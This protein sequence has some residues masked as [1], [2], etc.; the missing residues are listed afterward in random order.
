MPDKK[1]TPILQDIKGKPYETVASRTKRFRYDHG[2]GSIRTKIT[3]LDEVRVCCSCEVRNGD[4][5]ILGEEVAEEIFGSNYINETSAVENCSTSARGRALDAAGYN[6]SNEVA[7]YEEV[8]QAISRRSGSPTTAPQ[9]AR[10]ASESSTPV[11]PTSAKPKPR[12]AATAPEADAKAAARGDGTISITPKYVDEG[13]KKNGDPMWTAVDSTGRKFRVWTKEISD[14]IEAN[15]GAEITVS[16]G[17]KEGNFPQPITGVINA[18]N[19]ADP[20]PVPLPAGPTASD[21]PF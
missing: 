3:H 19:A 6:A 4:D 13:S 5:K 14:V 1:P 10:A 2:D 9:T 7:S 15:V 17:R 16:L 18:T 11:T 21:I 20:E 12:A 8:E